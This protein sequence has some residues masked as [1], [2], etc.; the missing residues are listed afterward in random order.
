MLIFAIANFGG[1]YFKKL[2]VASTARDYART[3]ALGNSLP[4]PPAG[5]ARVVDACAPGDTYAAG[6][7]D[8]DLHVLDPWPHHG[9]KDIS[10]TGRMRCGG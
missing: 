1:Y 8:H 3:L 6:D 7:V 2:D 4:T 5:W 10:V 9:P